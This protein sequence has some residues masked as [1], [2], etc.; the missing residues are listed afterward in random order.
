MQELRGEN[1]LQHDETNGHALARVRY[2]K[3]EKNG[4]G[5]VNFD[6]GGGLS[7][8]VGVRRR[9]HSHRSGVLWTPD[10]FE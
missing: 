1:Q 8:Q 6:F 5:A 7:T 10:S 2:A 4:S 9:S 3:T